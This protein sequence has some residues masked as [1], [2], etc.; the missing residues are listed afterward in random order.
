MRGV[1]AVG[2]AF[3]GGSLLVAGWAITATGA[4]SAPLGWLAIVD[5][6]IVLLG[7]F[8]NVQILFLLGFVL[9]IVYLAWAGSQLRTARG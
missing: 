2:D 8:F 4:L 1:N 9:A 7:L 3:T 6:V 5:A